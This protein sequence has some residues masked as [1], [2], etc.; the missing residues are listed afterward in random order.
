MAIHQ[1]GLAYDERGEGDVVVLVHGHPFDRTL[2][3]PQLAGL[4]SDLRVLAPD[5][6]GYGQSPVRAGT[7]IMRELADAVLELLDALEVKRSTIVG[8]SMGGLVAMELALARP[9]R[10]HGVVLAAT[11]AT[12]VTDTR[13]SMPGDPPPLRWRTTECSTSPWRCYPSSSEPAPDETQSW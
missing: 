2:W 10:V 1:P 8:L 4:A 12:A 6:P 13:R 9:A 3:A 5:P 11:T 7:V